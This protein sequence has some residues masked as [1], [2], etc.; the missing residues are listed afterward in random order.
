VNVFPYFKQSLKPC[1]LTLTLFP[2]TVGSLNKIG[3]LKFK[4]I[5]N[6]ILVGFTFD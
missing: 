2:F 5:Y 3:G 6:Y 1:T 4:Y